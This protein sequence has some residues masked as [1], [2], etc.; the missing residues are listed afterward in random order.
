MKKTTNLNL[1]KPEQTDNYNI[2]DLNKNADIIDETVNGLQTDVTAIKTTLSSGVGD[3]TAEKIAQAPAVTS[4]ADTSSIPISSNQGILSKINFANLKSIL[5]ATFNSEY[6]PTQHAST[7]TTH[8][9]GTSSNY[10][11]VRVVDNLTTTDSQNGVA[12]AARQGNALKVLIDKLQDK[13]DNSTADNTKDAIAAAGI[14]QTA[15]TGDVIPLLQLSSGDLKRIPFPTKDI[16]TI[17]SLDNSLPNSRLY[18]LS[19]GV[20]MF[21]TPTGKWISATTLKERRFQRLTLVS[22]GTGTTGD[23][24]ERT[25]SPFIFTVPAGASV[26]F[27][28]VENGLQCDT[29]ISRVSPNPE[30]IEILTPAT[31]LGTVVSDFAPV[32]TTYQIF[33]GLGTGAWDTESLDIWW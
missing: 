3:F 7:E 5:R 6:A 2:D 18:F 32:P 26:D 27:I 8:G 25:K 15:E 14:I 4:I 16:P 33:A 29:R 23:P 21:K 13:F 30:L 9:V 17:P 1:N 20:L 19:S 24:G 31:P 10:G 22:N 28:K 12:L 11:H